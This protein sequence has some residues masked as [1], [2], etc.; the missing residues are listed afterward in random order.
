MKLSILRV[1]ATTAYVV[2]SAQAQVAEQPVA[3]P[4]RSEAAVCDCSNEVNNCVAR[5][6]TK[7]SLREKEMTSSWQNKLRG[8]TEQHNAEMARVQ[9]QLH[10]LAKQHDDARKQIA[11]LAQAGGEVDELRHTLDAV[12][13]EYDQKLKDQH[14]LRKRFEEDVAELNL[15]LA[16]S[17]KSNQE[18]EAQ[19]RAR[20]E[21]LRHELALELETLSANLGSV[22]SINEKLDMKLR[23]Y[24]Q[25][26]YSNEHF[27]LMSRNIQKITRA[28][29]LGFKKNVNKLFNADVFE[30]VRLQA[31]VASAKMRPHTEFV[32]THASDFAEQHQLR[33]RLQTIQEHVQ[34]HLQQGREFVGQRM[35]R[36][37]RSL[38]AQ[39]SEIELMF[40]V[41]FE[42]RL[43]AFMYLFT[44]FWVLQ[45]V[46]TYIMNAALA[47]L[48]VLFGARAR[49]AVYSTVHF[50]YSFITW[51]LRFVLGKMETCVRAVVGRPKKASDASSKTAHGTCSIRK[52]NE[53][54]AGDCKSSVSGKSVDGG[55]S[56]SINAAAKGTDDRRGSRASVSSTDENKLG[57]SRASIPLATINKKV[58]KN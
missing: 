6:D 56:G 43:I 30:L 39:D 29:W 58:Y 12:R 26:I 17:L 5:Y 46:L 42:D 18:K 35:D 20:E 11:G 3:A 28:L 57:E 19:I 10:L 31:L 22:K 4:I 15:Q 51:P 2:I 48:R 7:L 21:K 32:Q 53:G 16:H 49:S 37:I 34:P 44:V 25:K 24:E 50:I 41:G 23:N 52:G 13:E 1:V 40:P 38:S 33:D 45:S 36:V 55:K 47:P 14:V 27:E 9:S 54:V 8:I